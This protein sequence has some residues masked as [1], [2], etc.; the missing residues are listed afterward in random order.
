[1]SQHPLWGFL[2]A[3]GGL[4]LFAGL[5]VSM[6]FRPDSFVRSSMFWKQGEMERTINRDSIR[7]AGVVFTASALWILYRVLF[8]SGAPW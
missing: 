8:G 1:M 7:V 6:T 4:L 3:A 5:G 2:I